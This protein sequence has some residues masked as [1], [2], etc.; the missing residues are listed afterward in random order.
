MRECSPPQTCHVSF[1]TCHLFFFFSD[2]VVELIGGGSVINGATPSSLVKTPPGFGTNI[3]LNKDGFLTLVYIYGS[4]PVYSSM[5][6]AATRPSFYAFCFVL[7]CFQTHITIFR[8]LLPNTYLQNPFLFMATTKISKPV[9]FSG[10][11]LK[12]TDCY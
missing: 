10:K 5:Y 7:H 11:R 8:F 6:C 9:F 12:T 2:K 4:G 3:I 1:V